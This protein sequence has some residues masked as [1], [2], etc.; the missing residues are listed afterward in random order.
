MTRDDIMA[1]QRLLRALGRDVA[2]DGAW[3]PQSRAAASEALRAA[4]GAVEPVTKLS[5][6]VTK[7]DP[8]AVELVKEFEGF[9]ALAYLCPAG[10]WTI[11][12]GT[13]AAAEVGIEPKAGM[14]ITEAEGE[15]YLTLAMEKFAAQIRPKITRPI[16]PAEFGAFLS[17]AYNIG[18]GAFARSSA[19]REFNEG[20]KEEAADA[21]LLWDKAGGNRL[22][23]LTRR[24]KAERELFLSK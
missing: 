9:R 20:N 3:G 10:V 13:T 2:I 7:L 6:P 24:R 23:G 5:D 21:I 15:V 22:A 12:Y 19:L 1:V 16:S 14:R 18:P 11:G 17:L 4:T 8:R